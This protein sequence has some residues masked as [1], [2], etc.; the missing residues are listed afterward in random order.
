VVNWLNPGGIETQLL[1]ILAGY[2]RN[3]FHMDV[4]AIGAH[5]GEL[6]PEAQKMGA[7]VFHCPKSINLWGFSQRFARA[8]AGKQ[9]D[10]VHSHFETW[11]GAIFRGAARAGIPV[12]LAHLHSLEAWPRGSISAAVGPGRFV[13]WLG[14]RWI[15]RYGAH[16]IAVSDAVAER[17]RKLFPHL[18]VV[19]WTAGIDT[20]VFSPEGAVEIPGA[21]N[22]L[23]VGG[24]LPGKRVDLLPLIASK[25]R[26]SAADVRLV[27]VGDGPMFHEVRRIAADLGLGDS[28]LFLG[29]RRDIP[30]LMRS[31][32]VF[33]SCSEVE[34]L[35]TVLLEAQA[36]GVP[37]VATDIPPH[38]EALAEPMRENLFAPGDWRTAAELT[39]RA[40]NDPLK[41][42]RDGAQGRA[43]VLR[44]FDFSLKIRE[45]Q[46][47][48]VYLC[49]GQG[50]NPTRTGRG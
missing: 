34:G 8:C 6:A 4:C 28:A 12:R 17:G 11:S 50:S 38:R 16:I 3:R 24:L 48:Y 43:H 20:R 37:V 22:I 15:N 19:K 40:L 7:E 9:Y 30:A 26:E 10:I 5:T 21:C 33:V 39:L 14:A 41:R 36:C 18:P 27:I 13:S 35:P 23:W 32:A 46:N 2:D 25:V 44:K 47:L 42:A 49:A 45:L 31:A 29:K 1:Q